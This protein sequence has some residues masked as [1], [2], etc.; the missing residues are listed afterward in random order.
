MTYALRRLLERWL[1]EGRFPREELRVR[2][3]IALP[4]TVVVLGLAV[5]LLLAQR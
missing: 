5:A 1:Q 3:W 4:G 2:W